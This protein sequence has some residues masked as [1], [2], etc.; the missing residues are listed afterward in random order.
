MGRDVLEGGEGGEGGSEKGGGVGWD[1][2]PPRVPLWSP[3]KWGQGWWL[4]NGFGAHRGGGGEERAIL[5]MAGVISSALGMHSLQKKTAGIQN[6]TFAVYPCSCATIGEFVPDF[7]VVFENWCPIFSA[8]NG[9]CR[10]NTTANFGA[11]LLPQ[12]LPFQM[13]PA[14]HPPVPGYSPLAALPYHT[15]LG[16]DGEAPHLMTHPEVEPAHNLTQTSLA[17]AHASNGAWS[18]PLAHGAKA[19]LSNVHLNGPL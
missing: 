11:L 8:P 17:P 12:M 18:P 5:G 4:S 14:P 15:S 10:Y 3:P 2:P 9:F 19:G 13:S 1:P 16:G 6:P 7:A